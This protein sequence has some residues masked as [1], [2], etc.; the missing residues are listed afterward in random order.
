MKSFQNHT[1][2]KKNWL[3]YERKFESRWSKNY[4]F[5]LSNANQTGRTDLERR[6]KNIKSVGLVG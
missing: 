1:N 4:S 6:Y 5:E 3:D 2:I